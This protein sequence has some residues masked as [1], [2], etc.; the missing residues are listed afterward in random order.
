MGSSNQYQAPT[1]N[2]G[3]EFTAILPRKSEHYEQT[4]GYG[5]MMRYG[6]MPFAAKCQPSRIKSWPT[7]GSKPRCD[8]ADLVSMEQ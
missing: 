7:Y 5:S 4:K 2:P 1:Q 8:P 3:C 6:L